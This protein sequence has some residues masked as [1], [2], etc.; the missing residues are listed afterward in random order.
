[1][2]RI[3]AV[4][5]RYR[6][7]RVAAG[8]IA[9]YLAV[10]AAAAAHAIASGDW[11]P[12]WWVADPVVL[13]SRFLWAQWRLYALIVVCAVN[14]WMWW[15]ILRGPALPRADG[16]PSG[17]VWARRL[18]YAS[19]VCD[20]LL[21]ELLDAA[22]GHVAGVGVVPGVADP[23]LWAATMILLIRVTSG[24]AVWFKVLA[25]ALGLVGVLLSLG[26]VLF[27]GAVEEQPPWPLGLASCVS[28]VMILVAQRRDGRWR[29][30]TINFGRV[31]VIATLLYP[32]LRL[33]LQEWLSAEAEMVLLSAYR[34]CFP[35]WLARTAHEL[36]VPAGPE[37][38]RPGESVPQPP[39]AARPAPY[40]EHA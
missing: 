13:T 39:S 26:D 17:V 37:E 34:L 20:L 27:S 33:A 23:L 2:T 21:W 32:L 14:A 19:V 36:A 11:R 28:S 24:V 16:L 3:R 8:V 10:A 4:V 7:G 25:A 9:L 15:M 22:A 6:F 18:L 12:L 29:D 30:A 5:G 35:V 31:A 1:M 40:G 38:T